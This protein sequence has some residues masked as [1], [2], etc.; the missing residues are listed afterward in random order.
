MTPTRTVLAALCL[1]VAAGQ[2]AYAQGGKD[3]PS[4]GPT[5]TP[6]PGTNVREG[7]DGRYTLGGTWYY[8]QDDGATGETQGYP[9]RRSLAGWS[10]ISLPHNWNGR[11]LSENRASV[12]W[13]RK[14]FRIPP[15]LCLAPRPREEKARSREATERGARLCD[16]FV[17][18]VTFLGANHHA[19]VWLNGRRIGA[20]KGGY[21]PFE[22]PLR[23]LRDGRNSLVVGVSTLRKPTDL[24]HWRAAKFNGFGTGGWWNFGGLQREVW[25]R[26]IDGLDVEALRVLPR[27]PKLKGPAH[28]QVVMRLRSYSPVPQRARLSLVLSRGKQRRRIAAG[29]QMVPRGARREVRV[30]FTIKNP[31]LWQPRKGALYGL[32][33]V[34]ESDSGRSL[35]RASFGVRQ[36]RTLKNG[37][38]RFNGRAM[39]A[40]GA[41]IHEDH[42]GVGSAWRAPQRKEALRNLRRLGATITRAHYPLHPAMLEMFDR[43]GIL[44]WNQAPVY[45]LPN[46]KLNRPGVRRAARAANVTTVEAN[47]NHP[48]ILAWSIGNEL[49]SEPSEFG[50]IGPGY[51]RFVTETAAAVRRLDNTRLVAIDR[52]SR[53][54]EPIRYRALRRLDAIGVNEYFGWYQAAVPWMSDSRTEDLLP[55][56]DSIHAQYP[57][58]PLFITEYGA[59]ASRAGDVS[60]KGTYDFQARW[61]SDHAILHGSRAY[62]N[63]S[64]VWALKDFRVHPAWGGGNPVPEPPWNNKGLIH[65]GGE[66]KPAFYSLANVF[67]HT[68]QF[69]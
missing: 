35:Y 59:E 8:R 50:V 38:V 62:V 1:L 20:H 7:Q 55:W 22:L 45:Q 54:G 47:I 63:G 23:G 48:S 29:V 5:D 10:Q 12:G 41:S 28:V 46:D 68:N 31:R 25:L 64:I 34:A 11:D 14:D 42:P 15:E 67:R 17:W 18:R 52:H 49:G 53:L 6:S 37:V 36:I 24:T 57:R 66:P 19:I 13:Y 56:L 32:A 61:M 44:V 2:T 69:K 33:A 39:R 27:L 43:A 40:R 21:F 16:R 58:T 4:P 65:E 3:T 26:R 60:E 9:E 51:G 30:S